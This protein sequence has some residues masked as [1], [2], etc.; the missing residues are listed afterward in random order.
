MRRK[1]NT[2]RT[3]LK[4]RGAEKLNYT[5]APYNSTKYLIENRSSPNFLEDD[6]PFDLCPFIPSHPKK[7]QNQCFFELSFNEY[8]IERQQSEISKVSTSLEEEENLKSNE[9]LPKEW[10]NEF[11]NI[12][13][14]RMSF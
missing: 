1:R 2:R 8:L 13:R 6:F 4:K 3:H 5:L 10:E 7:G 14:P 9:E 12:F 11:K